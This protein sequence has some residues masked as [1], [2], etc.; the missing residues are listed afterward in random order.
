[1]QTRW[2][3][4][5]QHKK[6]AW[7]F[8]T[9]TFKKRVENAVE[10]SW[11]WLSKCYLSRLIGHKLMCFLCIDF[12]CIL[13]LTEFDLW[14]SLGNFLTS[15]EAWSFLLWLNDRLIKVLVSQ[16]VVVLSMTWLL[17]L[18]WHIC[19]TVSHF[20]TFPDWVIKWFQSRWQKWAAFKTHKKCGREDLPSQLCRL[21][22]VAT[23]MPRKCL[24]HK[25]PTSYVQ[26]IACTIDLIRY[27]NFVCSPSILKQ[28][29]QCE[30]ALKQVPINGFKTRWCAF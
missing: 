28:W 7:S 9:G 27:L 17:C 14:S 25:N 2:S 1:M 5:A 30:F 18:A 19:R 16:H 10:D 6:S 24:G 4:W 21:L 3:I 22:Y 12:L 29:L 13:S 23:L 15:F 8:E 26:A 20:T 11:F